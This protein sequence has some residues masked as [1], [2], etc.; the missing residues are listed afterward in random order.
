M[1][2]LLLLCL[3]STIVV[4]AQISTGPVTQKASCAV[5]AVTG[6]VTVNCPGLDPAIVRILNEQ[7]KARL[8][9]RDLRLDQAV[10]EVNDWRDRYLDLSSR[11]ADLGENDARKR[12]AEDL[13]QAGKL[14]EASQVLD[15][16]DLLDKKV[17]ALAGRIDCSAATSEAF[18]IAIKGHAADR[19]IS[20]WHCRPENTVTPEVQTAFVLL[21]TSGQFPTSKAFLDQLLAAGFNPL[22]EIRPLSSPL[23]SNSAA[24]YYY[25]PVLRP[26]IDG[27]LDALKWLIKNAP[28]GYWVAYPTLM[29]DMTKI[30]RLPYAPFP[31]TTAVQAISMLRNAGVPVETDNYKAFRDAYRNWLETQAPTDLREPLSP[32]TGVAAMYARE[33]NHLY[34]SKPQPPDRA[35]LWHAI[36]DAFAPTSSGALHLAKSTTLAEMTEGDLTAANQS[37]QQLTNQLDHRTWWR[38]LPET[39]PNLQ[40]AARRQAISIFDS[41]GYVQVAHGELQDSDLSPI[42]T[43]E[44]AGYPNCNCVTARQLRDQLANASVRRDKIL[45]F[46]SAHSN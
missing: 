28:P 34:P 36:S 21:F 16:I 33:M 30:M 7:F 41:Y 31:T 2:R 44:P 23:S 37:I 4:R 10:K 32:P 11:L 35:D 3:F 24:P 22:K 14:D 5:A 20:M 38:K 19:V 9:D 27:N 29:E 15:A 6:N 46:R 17:D 13:L 18:A 45:A 12:K 42:G 25:A 1:K 39:T 26:L 8:K 43:R 40:E